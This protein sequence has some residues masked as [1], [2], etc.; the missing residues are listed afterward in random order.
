ME[1]AV[2]LFGLL[3]IGCTWMIAMSITTFN[4][5]I[6]E[7]HKALASMH[8]KVLKFES[9]LKVEKNRI[10]KRGYTRRGFEPEVRKEIVYKVPETISGDMTMKHD[11]KTAVV[12]VT[13]KVKDTK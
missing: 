5:K 2:I 3:S 7:I 11:G 6:A 13:L 10:E 1:Y 9:D 8:I 4:R 12:K